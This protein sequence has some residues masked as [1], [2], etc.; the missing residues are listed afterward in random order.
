MKQALSHGVAAQAT[1]TSTGVM[2]RVDSAPNGVPQHLAERRATPT[3]SARRH[4]TSGQG[5]TEPGGARPGVQRAPRGDR[6]I[7]GPEERGH[8]ARI[9]KETTTRAN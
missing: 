8:S 2:A 9:Q 6:S 7:V 1:R 4:R 3:D 5:G